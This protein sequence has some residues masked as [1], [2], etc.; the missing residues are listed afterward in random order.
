MS[1]HFPD[2]IKVWGF[3]SQQNS[4]YILITLMLQLKLSYKIFKCKEVIVNETN[5]NSKYFCI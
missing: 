2:L 5:K 4:L 3:F 1:S